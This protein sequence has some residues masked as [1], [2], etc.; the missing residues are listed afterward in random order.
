MV[1]GIIISH[2]SAMIIYITKEIRKMTV[3]CNKIS[4][5]CTPR[6]RNQLSSAFKG[7][8][9]GAGFKL[10][11][12]VIITRQYEI[13]INV[14]GTNMGLV[15]EKG[16]IAYLHLT[17]SNVFFCYSIKVHIKDD[18]KKIVLIL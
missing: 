13:F 11:L 8:F 15:Y 14:M 17:F 10:V 12:F 2:A 4:V 18:I 6:T 5:T 7:R 9:C 1:S 3:K 16:L